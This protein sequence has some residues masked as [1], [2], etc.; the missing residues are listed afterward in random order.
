VARLVL[1]HPA[2]DELGK[3]FPLPTHEVMVGRARECAIRIDRESVSR[4]H[5]RIYH[6][7]DGWYVEDLKSTNGCYVNDVPVARSVLH[8]A[9]FLK[10]GVAI[11]KVE[12][13]RRHRDST[14]RR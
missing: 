1:V 3:A 2:G 11:F 10:I 12:P 7:G 13:L 14:R 9:D 6:C 8:D 5:A 4:Q